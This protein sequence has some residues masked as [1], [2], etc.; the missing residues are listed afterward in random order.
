MIYDTIIIGL[1]CAGM[2]A[3]IYA[4][5]NN[6]NTLVLSKGMPG[7]LIN[8]TSI[9][10]NYLGMGNIPGPEIAMKMYEH[11]KSYNVPVINEQVIN[12]EIKN[13]NKIITTN[14]NVY[15]TKSVI[16]ATGRKNRQLK[17]DSAK[18]YEEK[19]ISYCALCDGNLYKDKDIVIVGAGNSAFEEGLY[20]ANICRKV[21]LLVRSNTIRATQQ[22]VDEL[23]NKNNIEIIYNAEIKSIEGNDKVERVIL[24]DETI[25]NVSGIFVYIGFEASTDFIKNL[26]IT[27]ST[28]YIN[29]NSDMETTIPGIFAC[30]DIVNKKVYQIVTAVSEGAIAGIN[31]NKYRIKEK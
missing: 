19:G 20:L 29:V 3:A 21:Y 10:G 30:G 15:K 8:Q 24:N 7:G 18:I 13:D 16:I 28:G 9:V 25:L 4:K 23:T 22:L 1:G 31:V 26:D 6:L 17:I 5:R 2:S 11:F 14:K 12:I 27:T